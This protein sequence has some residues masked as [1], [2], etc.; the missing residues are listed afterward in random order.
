LSEADRPVL[1][2]PW[3]ATYTVNVIGLRTF[4]IVLKMLFEFWL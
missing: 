4:G 2:D 3:V 1:S